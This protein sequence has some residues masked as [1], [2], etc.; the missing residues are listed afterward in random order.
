MRPRLFTGRPNVLLERTLLLE[1]L[2][3]DSATSFQALARILDAAQEPR[4]ILEPV[5]EPVVLGLEA[6]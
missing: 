3:L 2:E 1:V 5:I 4:I 6:D